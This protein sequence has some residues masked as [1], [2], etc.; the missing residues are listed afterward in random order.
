LIQA[1]NVT[2]RFEDI[3]AADNV[4]LDVPK[5]TILGMVGPFT[6]IKL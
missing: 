4:S 6:Q 1:V 5:G 2:K 3:V